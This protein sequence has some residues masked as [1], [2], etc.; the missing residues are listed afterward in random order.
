MK[1]HLFYNIC[2]FSKNDEWKNNIDVV[3]SLNPCCGT[4][5]WQESKTNA[6]FTPF[7][8]YRHWHFAGT[9]WWVNLKRL[10]SKPDWRK[11]NQN[12]FGV[13]DYLPLHFQPEEAF[14][15]GSPR[16]E[17]PYDI[18][19]VYHCRSCNIAFVGKSSVDHP[20]RPLCILCKKP[21]EPE[22]VCD[23]V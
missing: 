11:M 8:Q 2:P 18:E 23:G 3:L 9:F 5:F 22:A 4:Y 19:W 14:K 13:E 21:S 15:L 12:R 17:R 6:R 16:P 1:K 10:F 20:A 7:R